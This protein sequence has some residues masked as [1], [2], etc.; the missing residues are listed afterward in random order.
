M[1]EKKSQPRA[2]KARAVRPKKK[3]SP[4]K[5]SSTK[6]PAKRAANGV[7]RSLIAK[8]LPEKVWRTMHAVPH[9]QRQ[10]V[11]HGIF[12]AYADFAIKFKDWHSLVITGKTAVRP[13]S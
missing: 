4:I 2:K 1:S 7:G 8:H 6:A 3:R 13:A 9:G 10:K 5:K 12:K 11:L